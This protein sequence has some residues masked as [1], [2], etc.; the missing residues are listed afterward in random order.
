M[1]PPVYFL[2]F[3]T[4]FSHRNNV[5]AP[6]SGAETGLF[7][8]QDP[9]VNTKIE[10]V[11]LHGNYLRDLWRKPENRSNSGALYFPFGGVL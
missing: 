7:S 9:M 1:I 2:E 11:V 10:P 6:Q 8:Y 5:R 3:F 4:V